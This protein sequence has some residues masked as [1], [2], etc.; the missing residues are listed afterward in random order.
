MILL[1]ASQSIATEA[2]T[3][4]QPPG[5][6]W[7]RSA[8]GTPVTLGMLLIVILVLYRRI[9]QRVGREVDRA[10][11]AHSEQIDDLRRSLE[12]I[13]LE[14]E[15]LTEGQRFVQKVMS[16]RASMSPDA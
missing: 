6:S 9:V 2:Q 4:Q 15:R 12:T 8:P 10:S 1:Q 16:A 13:G 3:A 14:M 7:Q 5:P 11:A